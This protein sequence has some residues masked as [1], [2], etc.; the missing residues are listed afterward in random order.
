MTLG[1][2]KQRARTPD[3][4]TLR[5]TTLIGA[6]RRILADTGF[7]AVR[8]AD[9]AE[10]AGLAKGTAYRYFSTKEALFLGVLQ[11]ELS[12]W[13]DHMLTELPQT[14][15]VAVEPIAALIASSLA[16]R[17]VLLRL[18]GALHDRLEANA[19]VEEVMAFQQFLVSGMAQLGGRIE[20]AVELPAGEGA[21][22]LK[23][24]HV[25][26]QGIAQL[27]SPAPVVMDLITDYPQFKVLKTDFVSELTLCLTA[28]LH[29]AKAAL[30]TP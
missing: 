1:L 2:T 7:E 27:A 14:G 21:A 19:N 5:R 12:E 3:E 23:R 30:K 20:I 9:I 18:M 8:I 4:K 6:G 25:L 22:F 17:P 15:P 16:H 10:A 26:T 28:Q 11:T 24:A 13:F 29:Y